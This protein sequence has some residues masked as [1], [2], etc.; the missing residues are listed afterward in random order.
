MSRTL[1]DVSP[2]SAARGTSWTP[3]VAASNE[4]D[5]IAIGVG[6]AFLT[7]LSEIVLSNVDA[8]SVKGAAD[9]DMG[10]RYTAQLYIVLLQLN[11]A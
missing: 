7:K 4:P 1:L 8:T 10:H 11:S 9:E 2:A 3:T 6:G 5:A